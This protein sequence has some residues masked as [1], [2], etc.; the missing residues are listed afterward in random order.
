MGLA[1][2]QQAFIRA[3]GSDDPAVPPLPDGW[4][5]EIDEATGITFFA[6]KS[7][8]KRTW[9]RPVSGTAIAHTV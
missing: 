3:R 7:S 8:G 4:F 2:A 9:V 6:E 5:E 1:S